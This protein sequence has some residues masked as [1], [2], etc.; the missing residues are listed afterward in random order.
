ML[1][2]PPSQHQC[3]LWFANNMCE[4]HCCNLMI[5]TDWDCLMIHINVY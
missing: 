2:T 1:R 3:I 5:H 4:F